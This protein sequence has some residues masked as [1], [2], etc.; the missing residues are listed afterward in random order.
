MN[1]QA[2]I[3][4]GPALVARPVPIRLKVCGVTNPQQAA[5]LRGMGVE[6]L[7]LNFHPASPR[8]VPPQLARQIVLAWADPASVVG[9]FVDRPASEILEIQS[10]TGI[11]IAQL[12]GDES[13][14]AI[15]EVASAMP[16]IKAFRVKDKE[17]L[18]EASNQL[19]RLTSLKVEILAALIDGYCA[20][21]HGGTG[22]GV[23]KELVL[24][25]VSLYPNLILAGGLNPKN[26]A[27]R[28]AWFQPWAVDVASGVEVSPGLKDLD[29]V[30]SMQ[31]A[32]HEKFKKNGFT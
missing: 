19:N 16:V 13:D 8:Y 26:I 32:I 25:A 28:L 21:A 20:S 14:E 24:S 1:Q 12:H 23:A 30:V 29:A 22:V 31:R 27:D 2:K 4:S 5:D 11:G 7:G 6:L 15:A 17:S 9:V 18:A 10:L 3:A